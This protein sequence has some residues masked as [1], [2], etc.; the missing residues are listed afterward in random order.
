MSRFTQC[1]SAD[2]THAE[3]KDPSHAISHYFAC[4]P[5]KKRKG[6]L[7]EQSKTVQKQ[8]ESEEKRIQNLRRW[9]S[10]DAKTADP[11]KS[12]GLLGPGSGTSED[13]VENV[14]ESLSCWREH[15]KPWHK[16]LDPGSDI[17][18]KKEEA[19]RKEPHDPDKDQYNPTK[20]IKA[21]LIQY[22]LVDAKSSTGSKYYQGYPP[23]ADPKKPKE[24]NTDREPDASVWRGEFPNQKTVAFNVLHAT[25]NDSYLGDFYKEKAE[26]SK[27]GGR[28]KEKNQEKEDAAEDGMGSRG[29]VKCGYTVKQEGPEEQAEFLRYFHFPS[30][31]M[32][33]GTFSLISSLPFLSFSSPSYSP[34]PSM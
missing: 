32:A 26:L 25:S 14:K 31:N 33:V 22:R 23:Y 1:I 28:G 12:P 21:Y 9:I 19:S 5:Y 2:P 24:P 3:A 30:N 29:E 17:D 20:D 4:L 27:N 8:I 13:L 34:L 11:K 15:L 6:F 10:A 16:E 18:N 7:N